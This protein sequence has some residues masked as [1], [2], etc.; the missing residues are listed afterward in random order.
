MIC[1][2]RTVNDRFRQPRPPSLGRSVASQSRRH[3]AG[4]N[5]LEAPSQLII[6]I[7]IIIV[8]IIICFV[9]IIGITRVNMFQLHYLYYPLSSSQG[10]IR[11]ASLFSKHRAPNFWKWDGAPRLPGPQRGARC[12]RCP[13][14]PLPHALYGD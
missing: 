8:I 1:P 11:L 4:V 7:I 10:V 9:R 5:P 3:Q 14:G 6:T 2:G 12:G 13:P